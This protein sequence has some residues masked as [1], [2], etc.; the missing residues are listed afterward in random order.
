MTRKTQ[1]GTAQHTAHT[2]LRRVERD[3]A[4]ALEAK[5]HKRLGA[6]VDERGEVREVVHRR[7]VELLDRHDAVAVAV[8]DLVRQHL[9][10]FVLGV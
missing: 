2:H 7:A 5:V 6:A 10:L 4:A 8:V 1:H 9:G 3:K